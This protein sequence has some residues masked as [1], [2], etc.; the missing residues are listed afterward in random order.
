MLTL[1]DGVKYDNCT[2]YGI[3]NLRTIV[4]PEH[5]F[6]VVAEHDCNGLLLIK[7]NAKDKMV[8]LYDY[9]GDSYECLGDSFQLAL[10]RLITG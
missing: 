10:K 9:E 5:S 8:Y 3:G 4:T 6:V 2:I 1:S 7:K